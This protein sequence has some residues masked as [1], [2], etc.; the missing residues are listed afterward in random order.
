MMGL[1]RRSVASQFRLL[2][3]ALLI[4]FPVLAASTLANLWVQARNVRALTLTLGPALETNNA[5]LLHMTEASSFWSEQVHGGSPP[6][7]FRVKKPQVEA[8]L[9]AIDA[10]IAQGW[11][12]D[13]LQHRYSTLNA[14]QRSEVDAARRFMFAMGS[15][16]GT[17]QVP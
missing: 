17:T 6:T 13:D 2:G 8:D 4:L 11:I 7:S 12:S 14:Q 15:C 1:E 10:A 16:P 9:T 5:L 3:V